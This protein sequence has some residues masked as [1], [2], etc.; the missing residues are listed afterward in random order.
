M[1]TSELLS[2]EAEGSVS[3]TLALAPVPAARP[4]VSRFGTYYP[5][6]YRNWMLDA[7]KQLSDL[8]DP[9]FF[10]SKSQPLYVEVEAVCKRPAKPTNRYPMGDVDNYAKAIIDAIQKDGRVFADDKQVVWCVATK[11]YAVGAEE[12][13][14]RITIAD[15][16]EPWMDMQG[17]GW[18]VYDLPAESRVSLEEIVDDEG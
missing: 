1:A 18:D 16:I 17:N 2:R 10:W 7:A 13:F 15:S 5:K 11:R 4:R 12:P 8:P 6:T 9:T 14:S 3:I